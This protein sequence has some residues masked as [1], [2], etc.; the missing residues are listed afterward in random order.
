MPELLSEGQPRLKLNPIGDTGIAI[1]EIGLGTVKFGRNTGVKYPTGF[2]IPDDQ[3]LTELL[4]QARKLG[5]NYLDT[6]PAYGASESRLGKLIDDRD[7]YWIVSTKV[8]E[9]FENSVSRYDFSKAATE[10]SLTSSL[11]SLGREQL[12][13]V[14]VHSDGN[15]KQVI[16]QTDVLETLQAYKNKGL[17]KAIGFSG[18]DATGTA[19]ALPICDVFMITLN[20][21][22]ISQ[23]KLIENCQKQNKAVV[24]KK[25]LASGH[26]V[27]P[28][29]ALRFVNQYPG[30][31]SAIVGTINPEHLAANVRAITSARAV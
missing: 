6:A 10:A 21:D 14:Y 22:D 8:G 20:Q 9:Y 26:S 18:K 23:A 30:V 25:A 27:D 15:D 5:I 24:I 7:D 12:D 28:A 29:A 1:S 19:L 31:T 13:I 3:S 11:K 2:S 4:D 17:I 16:E